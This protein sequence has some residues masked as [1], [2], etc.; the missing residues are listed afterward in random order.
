MLKTILLFITIGFTVFSV[1]YKFSKAI[2]FIAYHEEE[3]QAGA[4]ADIFL[5]IGMTVLWTTYLSLF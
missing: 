2:R 1:N 4:Y 3:T 5:M